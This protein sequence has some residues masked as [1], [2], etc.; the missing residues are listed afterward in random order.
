MKRRILRFQLVETLSRLWPYLKPERR[1]LLLV[2]AATLGLTVVEVSVP[3][4]VGIFLDSL[5]SELSG[6]QPT[7]TAPLLNNRMII[8]LLAVGALLRG[9]L[10]YQQRSLSGRIGQRVPLGCA[11]PCGSTYRRCPLSTPVAA[12]RAGSWC[13]SSATPRPSKGWSLKG[14][15][16]SS[17]TSCLL[18][19]P[20]RCLPTLTCLWGS[21]RPC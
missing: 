7:T 8:A 18:S 14:W 17:R 1:R 15:S 12:D 19:G 20:S 16:S 4:L 5:L 10:L 2:A 11:T 21:L 9:Y 13:A 3:I 6:R